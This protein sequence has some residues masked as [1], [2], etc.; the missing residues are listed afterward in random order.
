[1]II[2][3]GANWDVFTI[4]GVLSTTRDS[5]TEPTP[6]ITGLRIG[7]FWQYIHEVTGIPPIW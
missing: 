3:E 1:M 4:I 2:I 5:T 6:L 7:Q